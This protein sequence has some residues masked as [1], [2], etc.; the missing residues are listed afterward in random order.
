MRTF[1][2]TIPA[3][4]L[5][6]CTLGANAQE[7]DKPKVVFNPYGY[8]VYEI[9]LDTYKS[10]DTRDGELYFYPLRED[11]DVNGEDINKKVQLQMLSLSSRIGTK[12]TGPD[13]LGAKTSGMI[14]IDFYATQNEYA[15][16]VRLRHAFFNLKWE[17]AELLMGHYWHPVVLSEVTPSVISFGAG[18][19]FHSLNRSPQ[20]RFTYYPSNVIR[21]SVTALTQG[22]HKSAGPTDAQ[23]NSGLP[24]VMLQ[25]AFGNRKTFITGVSAGYKWL[26]PRLE[27]AANYATD[28]TIGQYL[29]S[30]FIMGKKNSF[31]V[32]AEAVFGQNTTHLNMIG[33]YGMKTG[34]NTD[35]E[36]DYGYTN[37]RTFSTWMDCQQDRGK[38]GA[39]LFLGFSKL[40]GADDTY[41]S[42]TVGT[43][44]YFRNDDMD[45]LYRISPRL[46]YREQNLTLSFEYMLTSAIYGETWDAKHKV[47]SSMDPVYN[48][49]VNLRA[50]YEF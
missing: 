7:S 16:L 4:I 35:P 32:K 29:F 18:A 17:N 5:C 22:Y 12:Y 27:T 13:V 9:I 20:I 40:Y 46:T 8:V 21:I 36:Q 6:L 47:K 33:G 23:R 3:A 26:T 2:Q 10:L 25:T 14:E 45:Y 48:N 42:L 1:P 39:G 24:E 34:T 44:K 15:R 38:F 28:K 41:T 50:K 49:R 43:T 31:T 30:A 37:L 19:P 11:L